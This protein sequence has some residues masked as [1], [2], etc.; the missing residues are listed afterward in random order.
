MLLATDN[1]GRTVFHV[2]AAFCE[3]EVLQAKFNLA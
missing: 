2:A 3:L 1:R